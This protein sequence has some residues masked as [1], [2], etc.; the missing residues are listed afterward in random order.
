[1]ATSANFQPPPTYADVVTTDE[2]TRRSQFNPIW[3]SWFL[4]MAQFASQSG[5]TTNVLSA[6]T[7]GQTLIATGAGYPVWSS[8]FLSHAG[9]VGYTT[10][11]GGAVT[12]QTSRTTGVTLNKICGQITLFS[13]PGTAAWQEFQVTNST[14][15]ATDT[16]IANVASAT[17]DYAVRVTAVAAGSFT[18]SVSAVSGTATDAP[19]L[20]FAVIKAVAA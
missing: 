7:L 2:R 1:M 3:L 19:V 4:Q 17:N 11:A 6:G 8:N 10:G 12:Q 9:S 18:L 13:A 5:G 16:I 15:A 20:N 14:V